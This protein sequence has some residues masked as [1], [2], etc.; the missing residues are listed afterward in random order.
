MTS[1]N[2]CRICGSDQELVKRGSDLR[3]IH[4]CSPEGCEVASV[5]HRLADGSYC[6][7]PRHG[8]KIP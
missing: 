3:D 5:V 8:S 4:D 2:V 1:G 6:D 7:D